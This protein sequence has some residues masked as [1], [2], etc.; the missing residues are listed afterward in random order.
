M[1]DAGGVPVAA[2]CLPERVGDLSGDDE[3]DD[4]HYEALLA[5][6]PI[7]PDGSIPDHIQR[8][9]FRDTGPTALAAGGDPLIMMPSMTSMARGA[10]T[11]DVRTA[12]GS[13]A[14]LVANV[15]LGSQRP[16]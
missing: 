7:A 10:G 14:A 11:R 16:H 6:H 2:A 13:E 1:A 3:A 5:E 9:L 4:A 8:H 15:R 12:G